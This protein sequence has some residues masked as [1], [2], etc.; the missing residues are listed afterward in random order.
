M[1]AVD[2]KDD[3]QPDEK[4]IKGQHGP[5][6]APT[7]P[8]GTGTGTGTGTTDDDNMGDAM[9]RPNDPGGSSSSAHMIIVPEVPTITEVARKATTMTNRVQI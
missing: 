8:T 9:G 7:G 2:D 5:S 1:S 6:P 3:E 4:K